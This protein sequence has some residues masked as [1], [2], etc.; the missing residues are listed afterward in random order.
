MYTVSTA[1]KSAVYAQTRETKAKVEFELI[2][3]DAYDD[4]SVTVT[5]EA[6]FSKKDQVINLIRDMS[7]K[8]ATFEN[9]YWLLDGSFVLPPKASESGYEVGWW[10]AALCD[11]NGDFSVS[12]VCTIDFTVDHSSIGITITFDQQTNEYAE[13]FEIDVYDSSAV[14]LHNETV[15]GN[16]L[17]KYILEEN[18]TDFRQIVITI[19]KWATGNRRARI[20]E[21]DFG[22]IQE[23]TDTEIIKLDIL[24]ELDTL[25]NQVTANEIKLT[26]DNQSKDFNI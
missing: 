13:D 16:T 19:T 18:L 14:L 4:A 8:Y 24:E 2:D 10:S 7:G 11:A 25:S 21:V 5:G 1:F 12:Q 20:T 3:V 9:D 23:Y 22:I 15:T 17:A 6:S 26:L